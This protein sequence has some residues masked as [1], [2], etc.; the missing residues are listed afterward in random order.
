MKKKYLAI[1]GGVGGAKLVLGFSKILDPTQLTVVGNTAD[2]FEHLGLHISPDLDTLMYTLANRNNRKQGWGLAGESWNFMKALNSLGGETWFQLGDRDMATHV[3]RTRLLS[4]GRSLTEVTRYLCRKM[5]V[6]HSIIPMTDNTVATLVDTVGGEQLS[7]Q[8]YFV[9]E[10]CRPIV[11]GFQFQG[12][13][14]AQTSAPFQQIL[15]DPSLVVIVICP[16]NPYISIDPVLS[17]PGIRT[18]FQSTSVPI[19]AVTPIVRN[20][21]I[22]GPTAKMLKELGMSVSA[23]TVA[24]HYQD[25]LDGFILD[26]QDKNLVEEIETLGMAVTITNTIMKTLADRIRLA[27][28]TLDFAD[29]LLENS[30]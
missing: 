14:H 12:I 18:I 17:L 3:I 28:K 7:F 11:S 20:Q 2:D 27:N 29:Q 10:R 15:K 30:R 6:Q 23:T 5:G 9:R 21:A 1:S 19:V 4:E 16:S 25:F 22:K 24:R 8:Q 26:T 13:E